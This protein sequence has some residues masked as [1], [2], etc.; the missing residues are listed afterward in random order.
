MKLDDFIA[1]F[2]FIVDLTLQSYV[3]IIQ[4][5]SCTHQLGWLAGRNNYF[6]SFFHIWLLFD[7]QESV[8]NLFTFSLPT[9]L[10]GI[11]IKNRNFS[12]PHISNDL[13][14]VY[15]DQFYS[16]I[17]FI[18]IL[19]ANSIVAMCNTCKIKS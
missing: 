17:I 1:V 12:L 18:L 15:I 6:F 10:L 7:F 4:Q 9:T 14:I 13:F 11:L 3:K 19:R 2:D 8:Q 5:T 16:L